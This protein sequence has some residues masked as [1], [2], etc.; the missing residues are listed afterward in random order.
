MGIPISSQGSSTSS[1]AH[2]RASPHASHSTPPS[3]ISAISPILER[4]RVYRVVD[5]FD[6][7]LLVCEICGDF[8][9]DGLPLHVNEEKWLGEDARIV[10]AEVQH[11]ELVID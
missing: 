11:F 6:N 1:I 2:G 4:E 8:L 5:I 3:I 9:R 10:K 7:L